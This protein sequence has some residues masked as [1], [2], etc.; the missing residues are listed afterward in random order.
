MAHH[1]PGRAQLIAYFEGNITDISTR[2]AIEDYVAS[3]ADPLFIQDCMQTAWEKINT[4]EPLYSA[5]AHWDKFRMLAGIRRT[6]KSL[7]RP[8]FA[9]AA[10]LFLLIAFAAMYFIFRPHKAIPEIVWQ[11]VT[12]SPRE[13][14]TVHLPDGSTITVFPGST[15]SYNKLYNDKA[16]EVHLQGR[17]YFNIASAAGKPFSVTTGKYTTQVLGT[18]FEIFDQPQRGEL[19][20]VL[21]S[22]KVR[23][24]NEQK[25]KLSDLQPDQQMVIH[26]GNAQFS[27]VP[28]AAQSMV[29]WT[30]GRLSYDQARLADVCRDLENWYGTR[31][32]IHRAILGQK[33]ITAGFEGMPLSSVM[34][35]LSQTAGFTYKEVK[36]GIEVF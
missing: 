16:R 13:L 6:R 25:Q 1:Q 14:R 24:L 12:A 28:I 32:S 19:A 11:K 35:I 2:E 21:V 4:E 10:T 26:T 15:I 36:G 3:G 22:G 18:S 34:N 30:S 27:I 17:A 31:I 33:R 8:L 29:S 9:A 7:I 5:P 23:L 20:V